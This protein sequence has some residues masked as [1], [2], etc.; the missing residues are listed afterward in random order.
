MTDAG[1][2]DGVG[3][4]EQRV[5]AIADQL[6]EQFHDD[7]LVDVIHEVA[8]RGAT[9]RSTERLSRCGLTNSNANLPVEA[10][11]RRRWTRWRSARRSQIHRSL[12]DGRSGFVAVVCS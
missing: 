5:V 11:S 8:G 12:S 7:N 1:G 6:G 9:A 10:R 3:K 4:R 2:A